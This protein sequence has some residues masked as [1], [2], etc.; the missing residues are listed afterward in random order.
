M[1]WQILCHCS[2]IETWLLQVVNLRVQKKKKRNYN[3]FRVADLMSEFRKS[4]LTVSDSK[5]QSSEE[6]KTTTVSGCQILCQSS[7]I[8]N[9]LLQ[10]VNLIA[11]GSKSQSS[12]E[13]TE[14]TTFSRWQI[15]C[16]SSEIET[17]LLQIVNLRVH[18]TYLLSVLNKIRN[19]TFQFQRANL[20]SVKR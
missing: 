1:G 5:F 10:V 18:L 13:K 2:E 3:F 4:I 9:W 16:Q 14:N 20:L 19:H 11:S 12:E 6:E 17:W 15:L 7:D 8:E